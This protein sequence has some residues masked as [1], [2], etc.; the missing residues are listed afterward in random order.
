MGGCKKP[1]LELGGEPI[2]FRV[3]A[4][5][6]SVAGCVEV[7]P[8]LHAAEASDPELAGALT[9]RFGPVRTV[10]GGP[11][12]QASVFEGLRGLQSDAPVVLVHDAVRPLVSPDVVRRV[13]EAAA[14]HGGAIAAVPCSDTVKDVGEGGTVIQRTVPR[15]PLWLARTPQGFLRGILLDAEQRAADDGFCGTDEAQVVERIGG[16]V[17]VV[18]DTRDNLKITT[19]EDLAIAEAI[20]RWRAEES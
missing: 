12:R 13:A 18:E 6:R 20:L 3:I 9:D 2:L 14:V 5:M 8:V 4:T 16:K 1:L 10:P 7:L 17:C 19:R 15:E 11:T